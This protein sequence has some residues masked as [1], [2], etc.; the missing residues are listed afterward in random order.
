MKKRKK[1]DKLVKPEKRRRKPREKQKEKR[2]KKTENMWENRL[3]S[4]Q[5]RLALTNY[6]KLDVSVVASSAGD[7]LVEHGLI[8]AAL[9]FSIV[10]F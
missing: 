6:H 7:L 3:H 5:I 1:R 9:S 10:F 8:P 2:E 4:H